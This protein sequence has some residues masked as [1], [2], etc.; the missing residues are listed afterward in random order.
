MKS[1]AVAALVTEP[2]GVAAS[3]LLFVDD[4]AC[5]VRQVEQAFPGAR[6]VHVS[7]ALRD[8]RGNT[9]GGGMG[10]AEFRAIREW[11]AQV[12]RQG[13]RQTST[14]P[15][16]MKNDESDFEPDFEPESESP[17]AYRVHGQTQGDH[18]ML[19]KMRRQSVGEADTPL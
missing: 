6:V 3:G 7:P 18:L 16:T 17:E 4:D 5:N 15:H 14:K 10:D 9:G 13:E 8:R 19:V 1:R 2:L 12:G 11:L